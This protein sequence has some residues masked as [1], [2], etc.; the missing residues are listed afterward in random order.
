MSSPRHGDHLFESVSWPVAVEKHP[1]RREVPVGSNGGPR[2]ALAVV[3]RPPGCAP[4]RSTEE[5][6]IRRIQG[7]NFWPVGGLATR[8]GPAEKKVHWRPRIARDGKAAA[9]NRR[10]MFDTKLDLGCT[11]GRGN[12]TSAS[13]RPDGIETADSEGHHDRQ[14]NWSGRSGSSRLT[15]KSLHANEGAGD[16]SSALSGGCSEDRTECR[17]TPPAATA[18]LNQR[19]DVAHFHPTMG[20]SREAP[21]VQGALRQEAINVLTGHS[22]QCRGARRSDLAMGPEDDQFVPAGDSLEDL[23]HG[24]TELIRRVHLPGQ[25][26]C[27]PP[28]GRSGG[29]QN[30]HRLAVRVHSTMV[31]QTAITAT[32]YD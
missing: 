21:K 17:R 27:A 18:R 11:P 13:A 3:D 12:R 28:G 19:Q 5:G 8:P 1:R 16:A 9:P 20:A 24:G 31:M 10:L 22:Q 4:K 32:I 25:S 2:G 7:R 15:P 23:A 14:F 26:C 6:C 29:G 30:C